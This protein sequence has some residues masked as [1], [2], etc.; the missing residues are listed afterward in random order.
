[1]GSAQP[2]PLMVEAAHQECQAACVPV[3]VGDGIPE[4]HYS[5][6]EQIQDEHERHAKV[7]APASP[8]SESIGAWSPGG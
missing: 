4:L 2:F 6:G 8:Y 7:S 1:M 5:A 3:S